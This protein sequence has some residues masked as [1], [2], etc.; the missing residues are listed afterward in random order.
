MSE[1]CALEIME[2]NNMIKVN[3]TTWKYKIT[4][5]EDPSQEDIIKEIRLPCKNIQIKTGGKKFDKKFRT[6]MKKSGYVCTPTERY[7]DSNKFVKTSDID[8][9]IKELP[10]IE[11]VYLRKL[12]WFVKEYIEE[13]Y[14]YITIKNIDNRFKR[15]IFSINGYNNII[16][17][18]NNKIKTNRIKQAKQKE[19]EAIEFMEQL[20][21]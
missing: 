9:F 14:R 20:F 15:N 2:N 4:T 5:N 1:V 21:K 10:E 7:G 19:Q 16:E 6:L 3:N 13:N 18:T 11:I 12:C 17:L 8:K